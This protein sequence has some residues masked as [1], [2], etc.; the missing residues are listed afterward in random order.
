MKLKDRE[1]TV[2]KNPIVFRLNGE[3]IPMPPGTTSGQFDVYGQTLV[4]INGRVYEWKIPYRKIELGDRWVS[5]I[6]INF[7]TEEK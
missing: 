7:G 2:T 1:P 5:S 3:Q 6:T 4:W